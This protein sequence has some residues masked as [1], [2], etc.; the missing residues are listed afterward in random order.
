MGNL[1]GVLESKSQA[2]REE[3]RAAVQDWASGA[4]YFITVAKSQGFP[5]VSVF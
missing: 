1:Q 5:Q 3:G 4:S 2:V